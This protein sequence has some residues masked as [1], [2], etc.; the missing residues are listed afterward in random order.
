VED[1][2]AEDG[3]VEYRVVEYSEVGTP[4][5]ARIDGEVLASRRACG[6]VVVCSTVVHPIM[7]VIVPSPEKRCH[8]L[9]T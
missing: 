7:V 1:A 3:I 8:S 4:N 9:Q 2:P 5:A 6:I